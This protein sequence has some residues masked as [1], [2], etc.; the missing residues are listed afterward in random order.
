MQGAVGAIAVA[1]ACAGKYGYDN[2]RQTSGGPVSARELVIQD[3]MQDRGI[4]YPVGTSAVRVREL[5]S[6]G[7]ASTPA[8]YSPRGACR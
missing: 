3:G 5:K 8:G 2:W 6:L 7:T 4:I 1:S